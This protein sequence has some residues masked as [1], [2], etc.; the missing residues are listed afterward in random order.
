MK[1]LPDLSPRFGLIFSL[2]VLVLVAVLNTWAYLDRV[3]NN[4][5]SAWVTFDGQVAAAVPF[6]LGAVLGHWASRSLDLPPSHFGFVVLVLLVVLLAAVDLLSGG[7]LA[8]YPFLL[9]A[10][11]GITPGAILWPMEKVAT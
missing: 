10:L 6:A 3:A 4:T 2:V 9:W 5:I 1:R 7:A 11:F 8:R